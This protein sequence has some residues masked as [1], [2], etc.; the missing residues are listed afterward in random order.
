MAAYVHAVALT[1]DLFAQLVGEES[2]RE[3]GE[4]AAVQKEKDRTRI[5]FDIDAKSVLV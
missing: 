4:A 3:A 5:A 1:F 2:P